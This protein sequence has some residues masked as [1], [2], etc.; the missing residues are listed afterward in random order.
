MINR[1]RSFLAAAILAAFTL[2]I[3]SDAIHAQG[4]PWGGCP[5]TRICNLTN[6]TVT[7]N[8]WTTPPGA[9]PAITLVPG[10]C[11]TVPTPGIA[12][13]DSVLSAAGIWYPVLPPPPV[14]PCNCPPGTWSVCCVTLPSLP[15]PPT[16]CCCDVCF[17][18]LTCTININPSACPAALCR[19]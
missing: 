4:V 3:A 1:T 15:P 16:N 9:F 10:Q 14:P 2:I 11:I 6:C 18:P 17:D 7:L 19:P 13:I 12:S 8:L 5:N